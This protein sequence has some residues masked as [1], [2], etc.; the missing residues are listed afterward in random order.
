MANYLTPRT[1]QALPKLNLTKFQKKEPTKTTYDPNKQLEGYQKRLEASGI[2]PQEATD[3][4]NWLEK[5]LNL[6]PDQNIFFDILK[7]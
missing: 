6:T 1:P 4:R 2:D 3:S 5:A 7:F